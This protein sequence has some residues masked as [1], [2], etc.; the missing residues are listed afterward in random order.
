MADEEVLHGDFIRRDGS[1]SA[2]YVVRPAITDEELAAIEGGPLQVY[3]SVHRLIA[4]LR[5]S[6]SEV[7][8][9]TDDIVTLM[10]ELAK[11]DADIERL[12]QQVNGVPT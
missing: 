9:R 3:S 12:R 11:R 8:R 4:A 7:E 2:T 10:G 1:H 6:R 5:A